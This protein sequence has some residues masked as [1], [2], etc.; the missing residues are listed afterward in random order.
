MIVRW[1]TRGGWPSQLGLYSTISAYTR[2]DRV[3][4]FK[5]GITGNPDNR[6]AA[7]DY[8]EMVV[9]YETRSERH[10]RDL[11]AILV[12]DYRD[13]CDNKRRGGAGR[14]SGPPFY[15]YV[16]RNRS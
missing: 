3:S 1:Q 10:A 7:Y 9:L 8:D 15:L 14:L 5:I 16:V 11:E 2:S 6:A 4:T 13:Y 12:E